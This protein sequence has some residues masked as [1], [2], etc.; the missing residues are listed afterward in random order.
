MAVAKSKWAIIGTAGGI[1]G[2]ALVGLIFKVWGG[3]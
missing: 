1:I 3:K 2:T